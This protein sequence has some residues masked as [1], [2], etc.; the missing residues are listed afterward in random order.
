S[1][2]LANVR[3]WRSPVLLI[4]GDDDRNVEFR[5]TVQ[6]AEALRQ[7]GV[8]FEQLVFPD[9]VHE[10]LTHARWLQ[11]FRAAANFLERKLGGQDGRN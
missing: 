9:E 7:Q 5:Q 1:S 10:F 3:G 4:H 6:L 11:A 8:E 2:P